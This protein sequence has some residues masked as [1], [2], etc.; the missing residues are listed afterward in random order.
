MP[1]AMPL[2]AELFS[3]WDGH[4]TSL[5]NAIAPLTAD[6]LL[7]RPASDLH[8]V[9]ELA[10]HISLGRISWFERMTAPGSAELAA[11]IDTW[12]QDRDG[13]RHIVKSAIPIAG[14]A[15]ELVHW[16]E[17]TWQMIEK[18]LNTWDVSDLAATY[19]HTWN[20]TVCSISY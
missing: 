2:L 12:E 3:G 14:Q 1:S 16:L 6:Q 10:R 8:T 15:D 20:G 19:R 7:W 11:K 4:Q 9:G 17:I 18:T 13:N 5:V